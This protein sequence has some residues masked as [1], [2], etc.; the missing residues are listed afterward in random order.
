MREL[1]E[2][3]ESQRFPESELLQTLIQAV[4]EA[5]KCA[6][7]AAH[8]ATKKVRTRC[9]FLHFL[10]NYNYLLFSLLFNFFYYYCS[11]LRLLSLTEGQWLLRQFLLRLMILLSSRTRGSGEAKS[12]LTLEE[13][14][15]FHEQIESLACVV[16][17]GEAV[18]DL[19]TRVTTFQEEAVEML[20]Q[21]TPDS[22]VLTKMVDTGCSLDIDLPELPR[23][24]HKL[25]Q[26]VHCSFI[27]LQSVYIVRF[28]DQT[29]A[30]TVNGTLFMH[31]FHVLDV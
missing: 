3:A 28:L 18:K 7:V 12:R 21:D 30:A 9:V 23:L 5:E 25:Q 15:L 13:L 22:E 14:R 27:I 29:K 19:L 10:S 24:K 11:I 17:E 4:T 1:V 8:L 26:V 2:E 6:T 16:R 20:N 31:I